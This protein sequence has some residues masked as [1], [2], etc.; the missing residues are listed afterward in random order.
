MLSS[1]NP[2]G[3]QSTQTNR[4]QQQLLGPF[5][6]LGSNNCSGNGGESPHSSGY[7]SSGGLTPPHQSDLYNSSD[8]GF[9]P[10]SPDSSGQKTVSSDQDHSTTGLSLHDVA[11]EAELAMLQHAYSSDDSL[12]AQ[13]TSSNEETPNQFFI[14]QQ[15]AAQQHQQQRQQSVAA[16][17][18][19]V[20]SAAQKQQEQWNIMERLKWGQRQQ[21]ETWRLTQEEA[22]RRALET[23]PLAT[24]NLMN[25]QSQVMHG[26]QASQ[27]ALGLLYDYYHH[28]PN[29]RKLQQQAAV[30]QQ[31]VQATQSAVQK[32]NS[33]VSVKSEPVDHSF[34]TQ[35]SNRVKNETKKDSTKF[36]DIKKEPTMSPNGGLPETYKGEYF[37]YTMEAPR[38]LK[39][40]EGEP[41]MSY[42]N[43]A[44]FYSVNLREVGGQAWPYKSTKVKSVV[45][46]V[47][48]DGK[49]EDEQ[50]RHWRYWHGRQHTAKQRVID[51]ADYKES[52]MVTDIHEFAHNAISFNWDVNDAAKIF[53]SV[54]CLS[55]DF[56]A[57]KGI[58]GLPLLLQIDTYTDMRRNARPVHRAITQIK[59][60]CDKGAERKIRDEERKAIRKKNGS[61]GKTAGQTA[62]HLNMAMNLQNNLMNN[63]ANPQGNNQLM[64]GSKRHEV[65]FFKASPDLNTAVTY[66]IPELSCRTEADYL[67]AGEIPP[68]DS[69]FRKRTLDNEMESL[70]GPIIKKKRVED[71]DRVLLYIRE[72]DTE[73]YD[74]LMLESPDLN[75]LTKAICTKFGLKPADIDRIYK[76]SKKGIVL[77]MDDIVIKHYANEDTFIIQKIKLE[78][79]KL[80]IIFEQL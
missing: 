54:N 1:I 24:A 31:S 46:V 43:K 2:S 14:S 66:F 50:L 45:S 8:F 33:M 13:P 18:S 4:F 69:D 3:F 30:P 17:H 47:F 48:G 64:H 49:P 79:G 70:S 10:G 55:T 16:E 68:L 42:I 11:L 75:G 56:S 29:M 58:K 76:K 61:T 60:F 21:E 20:Q 72:A 25:L 35:T 77:N 19:A 52:S 7:N 15:Q 67:A 74:A 38:S 78:N 36:T 12:N 62:H 28:Q 51:I 34:E 5:D 37:E 26:E 65:V 40:K 22:W 6:Q 9:I 53:I 27:T 73:V 44:Q 41:T 57:Q 71:P 23:N 39:Q 59:V 32:S 80:K 63:I